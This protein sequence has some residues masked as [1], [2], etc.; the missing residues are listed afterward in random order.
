[1]GKYFPFSFFLNF[2]FLSVQLIQNVLKKSF[3]TLLQRSSSSSS[4][5]SNNFFCSFL[6]IFRVNKLQRTKVR[7]S[8]NNPLKCQSTYCHASQKKVLFLL[9]LLACLLALESRREVCIPSIKIYS[10]LFVQSTELQLVKAMLWFFSALMLCLTVHS[11]AT[12]I[13]GKERKKII[14]RHH[15]QQQQKKVK[16]NLVKHHWY[17]S[18]AHL[19]L[20]KFFRN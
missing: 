14:V 16:K 5:N 11:F 19:I 17:I 10:H 3:F 18:R 4:S 12:M 8:T 1:M 2:T 13:Q 20:F 7:A 6:H 15:M 9:L